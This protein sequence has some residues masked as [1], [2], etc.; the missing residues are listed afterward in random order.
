MDNSINKRCCARINQDNRCIVL[1]KNTYCSFH[2]CSYEG[3]KKQRVSEQQM[4]ELYPEKYFKYCKSHKCVVNKCDSLRDEDSYVCGSC[5]VE[6][7]WNIK[8]KQKR[9]NHKNYKNYK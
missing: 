2:T 4:E 5:K 3:C 8:T 7:K 6:Y 9:K 1:S